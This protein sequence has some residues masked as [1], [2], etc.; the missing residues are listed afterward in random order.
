MAVPPVGA[1]GAESTKALEQLSKAASNNSMDMK[2]AQAAPAESASMGNSIPASYEVPSEVSNGGTQPG[3]VNSVLDGVYTEIDKLGS[4]VPDAVSNT[5]PIDTYKNDIASQ[6]ET[7]NPQAEGALKPEKNN[8]V[9]ALSKTFDHAIFMA[10][11]NQVVS[12]V[13]DTSR[14]LIKQS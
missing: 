4:K 11:V 5:S 1:I 13:S 6:V 8:A 7:L 14:T 10:M 2:L 12:G 3:F 9:E